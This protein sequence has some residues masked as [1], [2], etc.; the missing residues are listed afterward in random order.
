MLWMLTLAG[1]PA[2][3]VT[4]SLGHA[5]QV[6]LVETKDFPDIRILTPGEGL[7]LLAPPC[8]VTL[9]QGVA[10]WAGFHRVVLKVARAV[11]YRVKHHLDVYRPQKIPADDG[12]MSWFA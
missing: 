6:E 9:Q 2:V 3:A 8:L 5:D 10:L 11:G 1:L 7:V 12:E 4:T